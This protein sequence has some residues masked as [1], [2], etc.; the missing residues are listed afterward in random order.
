MKK[1]K[2]SFLNKMK[3]LLLEERKNI[4]NLCE[5]P[6]DSVDSHGDDTDE[7]QANMLVQLANKL[8]ERNASRIS[9]INDALKKIND[10]TYGLCEDCGDCIPEKRLT[11]NP[12]F[13]TCISCG[14][15]S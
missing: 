6:V 9:K 10:N 8:N 1:I 11:I 12:H 13:L 15:Y 4:F 5:S 14:R 2:K 3:D 7:I